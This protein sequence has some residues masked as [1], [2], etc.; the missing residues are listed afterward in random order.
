MFHESLCLLEDHFEVSP[1]SSSPSFL[2]M[3]QILLQETSSSMALEDSLV[4]PFGV[5]T[6]L[7]MLMY[8]YQI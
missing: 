6:V 2:V 8:S 1:Y 7:F 3:E 5:D 4:R